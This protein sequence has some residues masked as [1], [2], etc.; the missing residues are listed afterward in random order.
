MTTCYKC[1][2]EIDDPSPVF[3]DGVRRHYCTEHACEQLGI[4]P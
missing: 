3:V 1:G 4:E 2:Q